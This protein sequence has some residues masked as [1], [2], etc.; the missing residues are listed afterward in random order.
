MTNDEQ[1]SKLYEYLDKRFG[2][3]HGEMNSRFEAVD[4]R[5]DD[6]T[7]IIDGYAAKLDTYAQEMAALDH[8]IR[9]LEKYIEVLAEKAG[10]DLASVRI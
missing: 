5:F 6:L 2:D 4:K 1:W 10:V 8:K 7:V 9:R 3:V